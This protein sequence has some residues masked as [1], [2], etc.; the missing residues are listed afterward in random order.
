[1]NSLRL[2]L[3]LFCISASS[4][5]K[6]QNISIDSTL[7]VAQKFYQINIDSAVYYATIAHKEALVKG[8]TQKIAKAIGYKSTFLL[9]QKKNDEAIDLLQFNLS[10]VAKLKSEDLG[11]TYN[12]LGVIYSL[13]EDDDLAIEYYFKAL[14]AFEVINHNRQL[15][16]VN[17]NLGI[18]YRNKDMMDQADYFFDQSLYY[19]KLSKDENIENIH[20]GLDENKRSSHKKNIEA[21][22][23]ALNSIEN[24]RASRLASIIY[25]DLSENYLSN[26][27]YNKAIEAAERA[28]ESKTNSRFT[29][30]LGY[31]YFLLGKAQLKNNK[32]LDGINSLKNAIAITNKEELKIAMYDNLVEGYKSLEQ[33]N[34][35]LEY[36]LI[37]NQLSDSIDSVTEKGNIAE[38]TAKYRNKKQEQEVVDLTRLTEE[39]EMLIAEKENKIW[40][41]SIAAIAALL[42]A[43]WLARRFFKSLK[44]VKKIEF[45]KQEIAKK[46]EQEYIILNNKTKVYLNVLKYIKS[47]GNYLEFVT[48]SKTIID[49]N[50]L[51]DVLNKLP[52]NFT[53]VHRSYL[54]N[55]NFIY[56]S[57]S[58]TVFLRPDIDIPLSRTFKVNLA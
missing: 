5:L 2:L 43:V 40:R 14:E 41:W 19:S 39:Q 38:I 27:Q 4:C 56:S 10:N 7:N 22:L 57:N 49:R 42:L 9:S 25:H 17:L 46:V 51:K 47:D 33:Y 20:E 1:M 18:V 23:K 54:V 58:K 31:T 30:N 21:A 32:T 34:S 13:K 52:P 36:A 45:E 28:I 24:K 29:Q 55:K 6:A 37:R 11:V 35:A 53:R 8:D 16:R 15:S 44:H 3:V 50:K 26:G 12:N 48:D